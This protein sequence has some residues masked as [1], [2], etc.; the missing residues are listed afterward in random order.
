[1]EG[2]LEPWGRDDDRGRITGGDRA[3]GAT[4]CHALGGGGPHGEDGGP[5]PHETAHWQ[6]HGG[7]M[8]WSARGAVWR[9]GGAL[10]MRQRHTTPMR[11]RQ[12]KNQRSSV[13]PRVRWIVAA[14]T[15]RPISA[16]PTP[17]LR[18]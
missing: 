11:T 8:P 16:S 1:M 18:R 14:N 3:R 4:L 7:G 17:L 9:R 2:P 12:L 10:W 15:S 6:G 13:T 5:T